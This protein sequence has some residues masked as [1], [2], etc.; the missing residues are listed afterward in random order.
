MIVIGA[1]NKQ[2]ERLKILSENGTLHVGDRLR[3]REYV[4][5]MLRKYAID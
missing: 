3:A 1:A 5:C 2:R 4:S